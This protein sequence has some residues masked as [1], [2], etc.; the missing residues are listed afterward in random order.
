M[1]GVLFGQ[2]QGLGYAAGYLNVVVFNQDGVKQT[3]A[4]VPAAA[5]PDGVFF[6]LAQARGGF[7]GIHTTAP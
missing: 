7:P 1:A 5:H 6:Q 3:L 2:F 4:V